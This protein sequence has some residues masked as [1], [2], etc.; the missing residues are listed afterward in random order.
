MIGFL[1]SFNGPVDID[2]DKVTL[3]VEGRQDGD[4]VN[5]TALVTAL[6]A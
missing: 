5:V 3:E 2:Y 1:V 6:L 4:E